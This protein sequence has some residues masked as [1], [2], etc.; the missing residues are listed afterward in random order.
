MA[1]KAEVYYTRHDGGVTLYIDGKPYTVSSTAPQFDQLLV[2]LKAK[3]WEKVRDLMN[4]G[5]T[6]TSLGKPK[7][8]KLAG[9]NV[10]VKDGKVYYTSPD[11]KTEELHGTI[12]QRILSIIGKPI[13]QKFADALL[14][15][16][17]NAMQN[18]YKDIR[19]ELYDFLQAGDQPITYDGCFLAY[20]KI[21]SN[22]MDIYTGKMDNSPGKIVRVE[23]FDTNRNNDCSAGLHFAAFGYLSHYSGETGNKIVIV[24]VNPKDVVAIP[25]DYAHQKGRA[26][27]YFVVGEFKKDAK[28][29]E[30]FKDTFIDE[31]TKNVSA[32][33][34][35]FIKTGLRP[36][37]EARAE[38]AHL[39]VTTDIFTKGGVYVVSDPKGHLIPVIWD[40]KKKTLT[41][42]A[43]DKWILQQGYTEP[44]FKS[45]LTKS[46]REAVK[47]AL[48]K[49]KL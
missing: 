30:A 3:N 6:I 16:I 18:P 40:T 17:H 22:N 9:M 19:S 12:T 48:D 1:T 49:A 35:D 24:K 38:A 45:I 15:F 8:K 42:L 43:G 34:I 46:V 44:D 7:S 11:G 10:F 39:L 13:A 4:L 47:K 32:P 31:A 28:L 36:S 25:K 2:Q 5:N 29:E 21:K 14:M 26:R 23:R 37:L 41:D 20:K 27:E 33:T